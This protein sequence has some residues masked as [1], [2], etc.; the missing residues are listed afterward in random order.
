[1]PGTAVFGTKGGLT[2]VLAPSLDRQPVA[3]ALRQRRTFATTGER[4]AAIMYTDDGLLQGDDVHLEPGQTIHFNYIV[5]GANGFSSIEAWD[6]NGVIWQRDLQAEA[7]ASTQAEELIVT[8][9][10]ARLYDR[11]RE[12]VWDGMISIEGDSTIKNVKPFGGVTDV[13][14]E[15]VTHRSDHEVAF[16][17]RTSGDFDGALISFSDTGKVPT[18]ISIQ[19][20]LSG[21]VK[22]GDALRRNRHKA[23]PNFVLEATI[24]ELRSSGGKS[25]QLLGGADLFVN[26]K[27]SNVDGLPT[28]VAGGFSITAKGA[29]EAR[30]VYLVGR[31]WNGG[32]VITSPVFLAVG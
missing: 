18:K 5:C 15:V 25:I 9:G 3:E 4:L 6:G 2:G 7:K 27:L 21:Y 22:V 8:W 19:G 11:Y 28:E 16:Q 10:G 20:T 1:M 14:E 29:G 17:T 31:E 32:K 24:E 26:A 23:H 30:S 13:P 12:A